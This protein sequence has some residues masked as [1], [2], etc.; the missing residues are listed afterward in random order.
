MEQYNQ[1]KARIHAYHDNDKAAENDAL[2]EFHNNF[3]YSHC[4][5]N[6][7]QVIIETIS[8]IIKERSKMVHISLTTSQLKTSTKKEI[9]ILLYHALEKLSIRFTTENRTSLKQLHIRCSCCNAVVCID[10]D[11]LYQN[12]IS[13]HNNTVFSTANRNEIL[14]SGTNFNYM[15]LQN[16]KKTRIVSHG[17]WM[18]ASCCPIVRHSI[19][20]T[21]LCETSAKV[22]FYSLNLA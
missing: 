1:Q 8:K 11:K 3:I 15:I 12:C 21:S 4:Y 19:M 9:G 14:L 20:T 6:I 7:G 16:A 22:I 17:S 2:K 5:I 18:V 10:S 13:N